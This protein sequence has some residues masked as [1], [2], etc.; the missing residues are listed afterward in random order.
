MSAHGLEIPQA[1]I[2]PQGGDQATDFPPHRSSR[3]PTK[4]DGPLTLGG[5][6]FAIR[7]VDQPRAQD[8][9]ISQASAV[10]QSDSPLPPVPPNSYPHSPHHAQPRASYDQKENQSNVE[11]I[12]P[13][14]ISGGSHFAIPRKQP[15]IASGSSTGSEPRPTAG[16]SSTHQVTSSSELNMA[17]REPRSRHVSQEGAP[18]RDDG[19]EPSPPAMELAP[20]LQYHHRNQSDTSG[21]KKPVESSS[22][23]GLHR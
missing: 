5:K 19:N 10:T 11:S 18:E 3:G 21:M 7:L 13:R 4:N 23:S 20:P 14:N 9:P 8:M 16:Q 22:N 6:N 1:G 15:R 17:R 12:S 2:H